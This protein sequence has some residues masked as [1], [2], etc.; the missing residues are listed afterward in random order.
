M[1]IAKLKPY[2]TYKP[3]DI[4]WLGEVPEH[5]DVVKASRVFDIGSGTTPPTDQPQHYGGDI[6]WVTTSELRE[7]L[8]TKTKKNVSRVALKNFPALRVFPKHS[9]ITAMYGATIGRVGYLGVSATVNQACCVF[10][11]SKVIDSAF[12]F[13]W[14]QSIRPYLISMSYGGGQP[15]L[16]QELLK[17][18]RVPAP[19]LPEQ[20]A[21]AR[22]LDYMDNRIQ[23]YIRAKQRLIELLEE[24]K[25]AVINQAVTRGLDPDVPLKPS[26]V[27]WLGDVP[28]HWE[29]RR[30]HTIAQVTPSN[31][32]KHVNEDETPIH[33]CNYVDVYK[34][35]EITSDLPFMAATAKPE[36]IVKFQLKKDDVL[37]TKDSE[38]WD[39]I[40]VP[41]LIAESMPN[42][43]C[44]YHLAM[45]R[46]T[47]AMLG[48]YLAWSIRSDPVAYQFH[49]VAKG[50]TR[51]GISRPGLQS[52]RVPTPP[53]E[54][55]RAIF[56]YVKSFAKGVEASVL[57]AKRQI[58]LIKEYRTRL[59]ADVVTGKLDVRD[60]AANLPDE[61]GEDELLE[62]SGD[63]ESLEAA[64][65]R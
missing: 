24:H 22:Y 57:S 35:D 30:L 5:W 44:G 56:D 25:R 59:V 53:I 16:S 1:T 39:D 51:Y 19:P 13:Y 18:I 37:I 12:M 2:P 60:A 63:L 46:P 4:E 38:T 3:S 15:N 9:V 28:A 17:S 14:L 7:T 58:E 34:N 31:V 64:K 41:A 65:I 23:Q 33:L 6:P 40:G 55:Q 45:L 21:I 52:V 62:P 27:E 47:K 36:E 50:V 10:A 29:V 42:V 8:V 32:D 26:G 11:E 49:V 48:G 54:E 61:L 20:R 43:I